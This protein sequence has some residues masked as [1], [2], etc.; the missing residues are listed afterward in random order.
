[1]A[2][3]STMAPTTVETST[4]KSSPMEAA[5]AGLSA[6]CVAPRDAPMAEATERARMHS[7][8]SVRHGG[9]M[10][11]NS[12]TKI[13]GMI[14]V[15]STRMKTIT[16]DDSRAVGAIRVVVVNDSPAMVPIESPI[17]PTPAEATKQ[18][19]S[20]S[21]PEADSRATHV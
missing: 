18:A 2:A 9:S 4:A 11:A 17:V 5:H 12:S 3:P 14:E 8:R 21:R 10:S 6:E 15:R 16:I 19:H 20:E 13:T 7:G 1:M